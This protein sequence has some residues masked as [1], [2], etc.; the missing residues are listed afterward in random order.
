MVT[1]VP[2]LLQIGV[3]FSFGQLDT[4]ELHRTPL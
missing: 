2:K 4:T 1:N 3:L